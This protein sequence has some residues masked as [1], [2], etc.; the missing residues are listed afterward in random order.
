MQLIAEFFKLRPWR[1]LLGLSWK[2]VDKEG[3]EIILLGDTNCNFSPEAFEKDSNRWQDL[4]CEQ[5]MLT[6]T[7]PCFWVYS[8]PAILDALL[9]WNFLSREKTS[10]K[11]WYK[12]KMVSL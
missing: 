10:E 7:S 12:E 8:H 6:K 2:I 3:K 4:K 9:S 1:C 5:N 11:Q